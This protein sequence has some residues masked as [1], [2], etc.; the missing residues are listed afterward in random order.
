LITPVPLVNEAGG[1]PDG[2]R[3]KDVVGAGGSV[4]EDIV[5]TPDAMGCAAND[6]VGKVEEIVA[7]PLGT[8]DDINVMPDAMGC[9]AA[10]APVVSVVASSP[11]L[12]TLA[13]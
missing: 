7:T 9:T 13:G 1:S 12:T 10:A 8:V 4:A 3:G 5:V 6:E 2:G 11:T